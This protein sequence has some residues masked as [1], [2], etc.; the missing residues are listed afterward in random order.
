MSFPKL[1]KYS[2]DHYDFNSATESIAKSD[3]EYGYMK[4]GLV[5][6]L[7]EDNNI[8]QQIFQIEHYVSKNKTFDLL[9]FGESFLHGFEGLTWN[10]DEDIKRALKQTD[11]KIK[12]ICKIAKSKRQIV[13]GFQ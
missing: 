3:I 1:N 9:C 8:E 5:S 13:D 6:G 2:S 11:K 12:Q 10:Y 7:M 4:I